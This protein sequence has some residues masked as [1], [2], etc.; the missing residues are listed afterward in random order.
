MELIKGNVILKFDK[1]EIE[2]LDRVIEMLQKVD[3]IT[4][5]L[6]CAEYDIRNLDEHYEAFRE[7]YTDDLELFSRYIKQNSYAIEIHE[8]KYY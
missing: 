5:D 1:E 6:N 3:E 7:E 8:R 4:R 2:E